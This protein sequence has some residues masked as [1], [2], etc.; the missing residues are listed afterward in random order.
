MCV[1]HVDGVHMPTTNEVMS[2]S[3]TK[4]LSQKIVSVLNSDTPQ[5]NWL[6]NFNSGLVLISIISKGQQ[7]AVVTAATIP[8]KCLFRY[9]CS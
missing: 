1:K 6:K 9:S 2:A 7:E 8:S 4:Y 5:N 3:H